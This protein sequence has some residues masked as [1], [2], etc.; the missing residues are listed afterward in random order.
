MINVQQKYEVCG[1][2][3]FLFKV[4]CKNILELLE[5]ALKLLLNRFYLK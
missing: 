2:F 3:Y 5:L 1:N 4:V